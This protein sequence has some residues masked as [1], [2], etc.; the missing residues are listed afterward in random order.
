[1]ELAGGAKARRKNPEEV[2]VFKSIRTAMFDLLA[3]QLA[4]E[5]YLQGRTYPSFDFGVCFCLVL[6]ALIP[7]TSYLL[8]MLDHQ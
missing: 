1:M 7:V 8:F 4:Y 5:T 3:T 6:D 2:T